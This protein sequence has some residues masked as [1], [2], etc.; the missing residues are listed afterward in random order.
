MDGNSDFKAYFACDGKFCSTC[1][2]EDCSKTSDPEHWNLFQERRRQG[3]LII[4]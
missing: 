2:N 4:L 1:D 3:I